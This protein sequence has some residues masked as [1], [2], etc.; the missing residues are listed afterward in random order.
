LSFK[1]GVSLFEKIIFLKYFNFLNCFKIVLFFYT[2]KFSD[3]FKFL[4]INTTYF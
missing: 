2:T 1:I 4:F 3:N